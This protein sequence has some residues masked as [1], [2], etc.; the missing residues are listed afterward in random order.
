MAEVPPPTISRA[1]KHRWAHFTKQVYE[2]D[3]LVYPQWAGPM[4]IIAFIEQ[5]AVIEKILTQLGLVP[6]PAHSS[7]DSIAA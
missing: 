4:R 5:S 2:A 7:P 1:L 6:A 3:P